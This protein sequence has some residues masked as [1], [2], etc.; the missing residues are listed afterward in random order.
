MCLFPSNFMSTI[1]MTPAA[2]II[3]VHG[4]WHSPECWSKVIAL[5]QARN[6]TC[7]AVQL[8][9]VLGDPSVNLGT[10]VAIVRDAITAETSAGRNVFVIGHSFGGVVA[11]SAIKGLARPR[12]IGTP[13]DSG[14]G[15]VVGHMLIATTYIST[16]QSLF[17][18][19]GG[20]TAPDSTT[21]DFEA[22][23]CHVAGDPAHWFYGDLPADEAAEWASKLRSQAIAPMTD[24]EH[25]YEGWMDVPTW[26]LA[27]KEDRIVYFESQKRWTQ[28]AR[29]AG[30][31]ITYREFEA[32]HSPFLSK[33][34]ET[35]AY[36]EEAVM[37]L[38]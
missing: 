33:P 1:K 9:G 18:R 12:D 25:S 36:I 30:A 14:H 3:F 15:H 11:S 6:Y 22:G 5:L 38:E 27:T 34:Q 23:M 37:S 35:A 7:I 13:T 16:G 28:E 32:S 26:F 20:N 24:K 29:D 10:D 19:F 21:L 8:S 31:H 4:A 2:S 17:D